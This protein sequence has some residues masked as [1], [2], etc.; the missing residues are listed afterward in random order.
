MSAQLLRFGMLVALASRFPGFAWSG[1]GVESI[2]DQLWFGWHV[3]A[4]RFASAAAHVHV[5]WLRSQIEADP[6]APEFIH[7]VRGVGYVFRRP[8]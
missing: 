5:H 8:S 6:G 2:R 1:R 4:A 3:V 7:T